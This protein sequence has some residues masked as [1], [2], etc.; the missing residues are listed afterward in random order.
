MFWNSYLSNTKI[1]ILPLTVNMKCFEIR[2][3]ELEEQT[4][5]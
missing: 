2:D 5:V 3:K 4:D 1:S